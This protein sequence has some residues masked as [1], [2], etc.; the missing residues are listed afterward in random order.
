MI[1]RYRLLATLFWLLLVCCVWAQEGIPVTFRLKLEQPAQ[2]VYLAG[3]F[4]DWQFQ[5]NPMRSD[6]GKLWTLT[7]HLMP[8]VYQYKFV[9]NGNDWRTDP[10]R[11]SVV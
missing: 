6:D 2:I 7:L 11:K 5:R 4:N 8:G 9:V 3:T 10:D 1:S